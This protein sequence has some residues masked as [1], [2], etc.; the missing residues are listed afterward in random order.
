MSKLM[1]HYLWEQECAF[2]DNPLESTKYIICDACKK[3]EKESMSHNITVK[4]EL[5]NE[6][7]NKILCD[8]CYDNLCYIDWVKKL[9]GNYPIY[10]K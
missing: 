3:R 9:T 2:E 6:S 4:D 5:T 8:D 7:S 1:E 10:M